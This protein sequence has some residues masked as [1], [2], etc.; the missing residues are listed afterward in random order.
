MLGKNLF[1]DDGSQN[2]FPYQPRSKM[3]E[4]KPDKGT[5]YVISWKSKGVHNFKPVALNGDYLRNIK[6]FRKNRNTI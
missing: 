1:C 5:D 2:M 6:Y 3:L 4:L